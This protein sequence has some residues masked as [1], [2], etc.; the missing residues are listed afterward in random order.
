M[1]LSVSRRTDIPAFYSEWFFN[2]LKAGFAEV[3]NPFNTRQVSRIPLTPEVVDCIVFWTKNPAPMLAR[4]D[5][6]KDYKYYFQFTLTGYGPDTEPGIKDKREVLATF[7]ELSG[8]IGKEKVIWRYDPIFLNDKYNTEWH[9]NCFDKLAAELAPYTSRV[10]ISFLDLYKKTERNT[11][12]LSITPLTPELMDKIAAGLAA[13][14]RRYG[15]E[16]QSCSEEIDLDKIGITHGACIDKKVIE[17]VMGWEID[18]KKDPT[19]R[20]VCG[21]MQSI[22]IGHYNTCKHLCRYC[23]ANF[24]EKMVHACAKSYDP[25]ATTLGGRLTGGEKITERKMTPLKRKPLVEEPT[26]F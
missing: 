2:R 12:P 24:N 1:I 19:Q 17:Q 13:T 20:A 4:L 3:I 10:V 7:K 23:Y 15:L 26:L 16:I 9:Q 11:K 18:I 5:E 8:R 21:C 14:A 25:A 22:D 6:L